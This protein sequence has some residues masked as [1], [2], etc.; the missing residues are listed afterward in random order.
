MRIAGWMPKATNT[1][2]KYVIIIAHPLQEWLHEHCSIKRKK[3]T[4]C[5]IFTTLIGTTQ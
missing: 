2:S 4:A 5:F 1:N 3:H